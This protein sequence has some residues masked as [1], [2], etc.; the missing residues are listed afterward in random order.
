MLIK[1]LKKYLLISINKIIKKPIN[2]FKKL[3]DIQF[4]Y[5][6]NNQILGMGIPSI[7][8]IALSIAN[9]FPSLLSS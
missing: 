8:E 6:K 5:Y 7:L 1:N 9:I 4:L 2:N 3:L